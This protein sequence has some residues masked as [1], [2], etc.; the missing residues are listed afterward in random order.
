MEAKLLVGVLVFV[1]M[2]SG[3]IAFAGRKF[4][5]V[6]DHRHNFAQGSGRLE[7]VNETEICIFCHTPHG[8]EASSQL[9]NRQ[10]PL[11]PFN[12][13]AGALSIKGPVPEAQYGTDY[14]NGS[15]RL[16]LSCH[17]GVSSVGAILNPSNKTLELP[18]IMAFDT[19][20]DYNSLGAGLHP[21]NPE[22]MIVKLEQSHPVSFV[23]D[24]NVVAALNG[25]VPGSYNFPVDPAIIRLDAKSRMQCTA[26]HDP[27]DDT[28]VEPTYTLPFWT[29]H[30]N[31]P[32]GDYD[33]V[34]QQCH[35]GTPFGNTH[36]M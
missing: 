20:A 33:A 24:A 13:Y 18:I 26:C 25:I 1:V 22:G 9:W 34:C 5:D 21:D 27:H 2:I 19:L 35:T 3:D 30:N 32:V 10:Q 12:L 4:T 15:T 7:A 23:Y 16:C 31:N 28:R 14:P 6:G 11:G 36:Q 17:D 29:Y 8:A